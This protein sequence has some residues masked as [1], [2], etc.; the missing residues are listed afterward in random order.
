MPC[1]GLLQ[2]CTEQVGVRVENCV[3]SSG[4]KEMLH[5]EHGGTLG[6]QRRRE[7]T[8]MCCLPCNYNHGFCRTRC[9]QQV[10]SRGPGTIRRASQ[11]LGGLPSSEGHHRWGGAVLG[12]SPPAVA[13]HH[14][15]RATADTQ[16]ERGRCFSSVKPPRHHRQRAH[17]VITATRCE[18]STIGRSAFKG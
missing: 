7:T 9:P 13:P 1:P 11:Y 4:T 16:K 3:P 18:P 2:T 14:L 6:P 10:R 8:Q 5:R 12:R 15:D 17:H